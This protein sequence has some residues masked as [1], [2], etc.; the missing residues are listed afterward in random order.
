MHL[1]NHRADPKVMVPG[2]GLWVELMQKVRV[3]SKQDQER[4][5]QGE[6]ENL[7]HLGP[8]SQEN[9][10]NKGKCGKCA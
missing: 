3:A 6:E 8:G 5:A 2:T 7:R 4:V 1:V 10:F 9:C